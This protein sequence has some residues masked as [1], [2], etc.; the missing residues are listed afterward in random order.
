MYSRQ[1][2]VW[3]LIVWALTW[4]LTW[5][6]C[7]WF[8]CLHLESEREGKEEGGGGRVCKGGRGMGI[9]KSYNKE[10]T[11]MTKNARSDTPPWPV[12]TSESVSF[13]NGTLMPRTGWGMT[14]GLWHVLC[15]CV[16]ITRNTHKLTSDWKPGTLVKWPWLN[17]CLPLPSLAWLVWVPLWSRH[18]Y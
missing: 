18:I 3:G 4:Q 8:K 7:Y 9:S 15:M 17:S 5:K 6:I 11:V 2:V 13:V 12:L 14:L 16:L 1:N 10:Q